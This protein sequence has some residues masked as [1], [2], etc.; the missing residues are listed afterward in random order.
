MYQNVSI[1]IT[2]YKSNGY[3]KQND[4]RKKFYIALSFLFTNAQKGN[5]VSGEILGI[6]YLYKR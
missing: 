5:F 2:N 1:I 4:E 3:N 6:E